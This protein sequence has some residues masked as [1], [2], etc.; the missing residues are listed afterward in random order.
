MPGT[1]GWT[2]Q[3]IAP[4]VSNVI[5]RECGNAFTASILR[6]TAHAQSVTA[7]GA[8]TGDQLQQLLWSDGRLRDAHAEWRKRVL[9]RRDHSGRRGDRRDLARAL[10]AE[11]IERG[12]R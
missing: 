11:R 3:S 2:S 4:W 1:A 5:V 6:A 9:D 12:G 8:P 7:A 10:G